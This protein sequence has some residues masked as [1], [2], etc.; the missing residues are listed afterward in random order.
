MTQRL[1]DNNMKTITRVSG[2]RA[3]VAARQCILCGWALGNTETGDWGLNVHSKRL[4]SVR[5]RTI[6]FIM[7]ERYA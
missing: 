2:I 4:Y 7:I 3:V 1:V 6:D 5:I